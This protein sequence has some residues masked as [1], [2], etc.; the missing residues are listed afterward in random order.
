MSA[1]MFRA[2]LVVVVVLGLAAL[3]VMFIPTERAGSDCGT[4]PAPEYS[5]ARIAELAESYAGVD[6]ESLEALGEGDVV[7]GLAADARGVAVAK[8][9]CDEA[10]STRR[11]LT[12]GLLAGLVVVP[13]VA[14]FVGR[15]KR[16]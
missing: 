16:D 4:W 2:T 1:T 15:A 8:I 10:L 12:L 6:V 13:A 5:D 14:V 3:A 9:A 11:N 7:A